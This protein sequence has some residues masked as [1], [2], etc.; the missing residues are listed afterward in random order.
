MFHRFRRR[1]PAR[2]AVARKAKR[3]PGGALSQYGTAAFPMSPRKPAS[4]PPARG[5]DAPSAITIM[6]AA[7]ISSWACRTE[8]PFTTTKAAGDFGMSRQSTGIKF[9]GSAVGTH[10][11]GF[12][13]RWRSRPLY[14]PLHRFHTFRPAVSSISRSAVRRREMF[15]G[16]TTETELLQIGQLRLDWR[17]MPPAFAALASDLN[18]D[19][20]VDL[21]LTGWRRAAAVLT[22]PRE[23][24]FRHIGTLEL[25]FP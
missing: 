3:P 4:A 11:C 14:I 10:L 9:R 8:S 21:I 23:G 22:N 24:P 5:M 20:A 19:R 12:R 13:S 16:A 25:A 18:N 17:E 6:T 1:R 15:S 7:T 2:S